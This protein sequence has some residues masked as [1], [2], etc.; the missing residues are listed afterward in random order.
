MSDELDSFVKDSLSQGLG[1]SAI[2]DVLLQA[3]WRE[4]EL[5]TAFSSY[6]EIDFPVPV[7]RPKPYL[8]AREAFLYLV[9]F[10][11]LYV[12]AF[13]LITLI[14]GFIDKAFPDPLS[15]RGGYQ[16]E[17]ISGTLR[18]ALASIIVTFPVYLFL[19][20]RL[21]KDAAVYPERRQSRL[22]KWRTYLTLVVASSIITG[23]LITMLAK[24]LGGDLTIPF[25]L[26]VLT[27]LLIIG[28]IF[29][30]Y[31]WDLRQSERVGRE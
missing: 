11:S 7:P 14:F 21:T 24:L 31:L 25:I 17:F 30:F 26:K 18:M 9:S 2:R 29:G 10:I 20:W 4:D 28:S 13:S 6:A 8:Q 16:G 23:D 5:T 1:R 22:R 15:Y 19:M 3:G 12:P 27:I